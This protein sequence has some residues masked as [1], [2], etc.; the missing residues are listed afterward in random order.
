MAPAFMIQKSSTPSC[1]LPEVPEALYHLQ[2][3]LS[4]PFPPYLLQFRTRAQTLM[5]RERGQL[6]YDIQVLT[7]S[8]AVCITQLRAH[9]CHR[10]WMCC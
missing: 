10:A 2:K 5:V 6:P 7:F 8:L 9:G 3:L 1:S 4:K